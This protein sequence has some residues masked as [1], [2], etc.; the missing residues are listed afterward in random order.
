VAV[1]LFIQA[2]LVSPSAPVLVLANNSPML[3]PAPATV[4]S[5]LLAL[6][7]ERSVG[8]LVDVDG[9]IVSR[10]AGWK[11]RAALN[12][13]VVPTASLLSHGDRLE[14]VA[15]L[16]R[17]ERLE[18]EV[19]EVILADQ[20]EGKGEYT[21]VRAVGVAGKKLIVRGAKSGKIVSI[22]NLSEARPFMIARTAE[23]PDKPIA[24]TFDDGPT[25]PY[26][27]QIT[28]ILSD[29]YGTG[30]F[31]VL[32][33]QAALFSRTVQDLDAAG[34]QVANHTYSHN[35]LDGADEATVIRELDAASATVVP[36]TGKPMQWFRPPYGYVSDS[37][38]VMAARRG[39]HTVRWHIDS[40]DWDG[41]SP[42]AIAERVLAEAR[43]GAIVLLHDGGGDRT[44]TVKALPHIIKELYER[45]F[46][47]VTVEQLAK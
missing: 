32:G 25:P 42:E 28:E 36:L 9:V 26:T 27:N 46:S 47:L 37:L 40:R 7:M 23:K 20:V 22:R 5:A 41:L 44:N 24:L 18:T 29:L 38:R 13:R 2:L 19:V 8:D 43:P 12:G 10:G 1:F 6:G 3:L 14:A 15:A 39:Y 17:T 30:T 11:A 33:S 35:R 21:T 34:F 45:G 4:D 16:D 31:F